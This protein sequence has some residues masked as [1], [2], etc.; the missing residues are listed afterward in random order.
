MLNRYKRLLIF[1]KFII[2]KTNKN[3]VQLG[4]SIFQSETNDSVFPEVKVGWYVLQAGNF[5]RIR[6]LP[7]TVKALSTGLIQTRARLK[8]NVD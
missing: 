8:G 6:M 1:F 2:M 4:I 7:R 5:R 3:S